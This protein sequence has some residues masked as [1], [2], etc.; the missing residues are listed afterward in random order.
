MR[1]HDLFQRGTLFRTE[2]LNKTSRC[3]HDHAI[4]PENFCLGA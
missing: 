4:L 1:L 3:F 2:R